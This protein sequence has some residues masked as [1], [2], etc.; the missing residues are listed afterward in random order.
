MSAVM[1]FELEY[2]N[3]LSGAR[4]RC[5]CSVF[6]PV[7]G[8]RSIRPGVIVLTELADN[9]GPSVTNSIEWIAAELENVLRVPLL[10]G[11][12]LV[13]HYPANSIRSATFDVVEIGN[14]GQRWYGPKWRH[15]TEE[16]LDDLTRGSSHRPADVLNQWEPKKEEVPTI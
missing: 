6:L 1:S 8:R 10:S 2:R 5:G 9:P 14:D 16:H 13:E 15:I 4:G 12:R 11:Y 3:G 7:A